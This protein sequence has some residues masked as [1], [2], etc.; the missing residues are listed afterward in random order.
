MTLTINTTQ[1]ANM[2]KLADILRDGASADIWYDT[3]T[4]GDDADREIS[5]TEQILNTKNA[6]Y[7]AANILETLA[8]ELL[9]R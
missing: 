6:M 1:S 2:D 8:D 3:D 9:A 4:F 5:Y 7:E